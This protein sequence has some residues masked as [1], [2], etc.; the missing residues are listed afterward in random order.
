[1]AITSFAYAGSYTEDVEGNILKYIIM[2]IGIKKYII[3]KI[4]ASFYAAF[5]VI[6]IGTSL[7]LKKT[8]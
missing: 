1:M 8:C 4:L 7:K 5:L 6:E 2:R 3:S